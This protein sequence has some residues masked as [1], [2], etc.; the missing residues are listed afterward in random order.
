[1]KLRWG[2]TRAAPN[3]SVRRVG[4]QVSALT[5]S[6]GREAE[7]GAPVSLPFTYAIR[8]DRRR[9][10][11]EGLSL[12]CSVLTGSPFSF[13][14]PAVRPS[15]LRPD[16]SRRPPSLFQKGSRLGPWTKLKAAVTPNRSGPRSRPHP[17]LPVRKACPSAPGSAW[18]SAPSEPPAPR[19][20]HPPSLSNTNAQSSEAGEFC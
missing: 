13:P 6:M 17:G 11:R 15:C 2:D 7:L 12:R 3:R 1:M 16:P 14:R 8:A 5:A 18:V 10:F 4:G 9:E 19:S 20:S